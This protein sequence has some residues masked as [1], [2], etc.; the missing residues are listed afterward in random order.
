M[1]VDVYVGIQAQWEGESAAS[2]LSDG[3]ASLEQVMSYRFFL[4]IKCGTGRLRTNLVCG[5]F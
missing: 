3:T 2:D 1:D 4:F 5:V